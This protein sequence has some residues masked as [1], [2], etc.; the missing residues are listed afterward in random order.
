MKKNGRNEER[1]SRES[2]T[3]NEDIILL[4]LLKLGGHVAEIWWKKSDDST[5]PLTRGKDMAGERAP[6]SVLFLWRERFGG[7]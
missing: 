4:Q 1:E 3:K 5:L 6:A 2:A 7:S